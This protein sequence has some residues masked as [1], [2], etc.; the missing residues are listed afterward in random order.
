[1]KINPINQ[2]MYS[3]VYSQDVKKENN[4]VSK[5]TTNCQEQNPSFKSLLVYV[6][7]KTGIQSIQGG[8]KNEYLSQLRKC[9]HRMPVEGLSG[10]SASARD[11]ILK[12]FIAAVE[13]ITKT[14]DNFND[15]TVGE[16]AGRVVLGTIAAPVVA[17]A[18][19]MG[20]DINVDERPSVSN[21]RED[22]L[23]RIQN[24][25]DINYRNIQTKK[26]F[27]NSYLTNGRMLYSNFIDKFEE[28]DSVKYKNFKEEFI[29]KVLYSSEYKNKLKESFP[30]LSQQE[31]TNTRLS[32]I[33]TLDPNVNRYFLQSKKPLIDMWERSV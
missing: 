27:F 18:H 3:A 5:Q 21:L 11:S 1:M 28:L 12:D 15:I 29:D 6:V 14:P 24:I 8:K 7:A 33:K 23:Y 31:L 25:S 16:F 17:A 4:L 10:Y 9:I 26:D 22:V 30:Y 2:S 13:A 19:F 32:L 20:V